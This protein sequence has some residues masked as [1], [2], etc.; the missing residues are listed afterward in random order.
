MFFSRL[1]AVLSGFVLLTTAAQASA[2]MT[3]VAAVSAPEPARAA[4]PGVEPLR[5]SLSLERVGGFNYS[6]ISDADSDAHASFT[7]LSVGG[8]TL[9][10]YASP[11][12][13][14]D[15][16]VWE[17]LTLGG[18][19]SYSRTSLTLSEESG[20][21][22][23]PESKS[24]NVGSLTMYSV[25]PRVGYVLRPHPKLDVALRAGLLLA[26][27]SLKDSDGDGV[28]VFTTA[29]DAE[30]VGAVRLTTSF[31]LLIGLAFDR[32]LSGSASEENSSSDSSGSARE[33]STTIDGGLTTGQLWLG[34]GG[35]L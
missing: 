8:I 33:S 2:Q 4:T 25:T 20:D 16:P 22:G 14:V 12:L 23:S 1:S 3:A 18:S 32:T 17:A 35:Y 13:G 10:P 29:L 15:I 11:R 7:L 27:G 26:G 30:V 24:E 5:L 19:V 34:L 9:N 28:S 6:R 21:A 31:N